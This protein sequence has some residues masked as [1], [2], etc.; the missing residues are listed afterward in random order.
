M[1]DIDEALIEGGDSAAATPVEP[2]DTVAEAVAAAVR[3]AQGEPAPEPAAKAESEGEPKT[4]R[5]DGRDAQGRFA[6]K[7]P[8]TPEPVQTASQPQQQASSFAPPPGWSAQAKAAFGQLPAE[9]QAAVAQREDEVN[10][11]FQVLQNYKGLEQFNDFV[12]GANTTH[13]Q[14]MERAIGWERALIADPVG[15]ALHAAAQRGVTPQML[16]QAI[17]NPAY[18][19]QLRAHMARQGAPQPQPQQQRPALSIEEVRRA[20]REEA[21]RAHTERQ[22]NSDISAFFAD[23]KYP[24]AAGLEE[25]MAFFIEHGRAADLLEHVRE[26]GH[27]R[28]VVVH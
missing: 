1:E 28:A 20:A 8:A 11:G 10:R 18:A 27:V 12:R 21:E 9:V 22:I 6:P 19:Q 2:P 24:H 17:T 13:A 26:L 16:V 25:D 5:A 3:K 4:A 14:V 23:P 7:E 15:T